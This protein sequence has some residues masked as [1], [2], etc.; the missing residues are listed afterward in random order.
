MHRAGWGASPE[1]QPEDGGRGE[2]DDDHGGRRAW[3]DALGDLVEGAHGAGR[4]EGVG[5]RAVPSYTAPS[6]SVLVQR[7]HCSAGMT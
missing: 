6:G 1:D 4:R 3:L 7:P 2:G 5:G